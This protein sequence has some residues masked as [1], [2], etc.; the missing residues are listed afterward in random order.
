[1]KTQ[2]LH[3]E[4]YDDRHSISDKLDWGHA[5][6]A[7]LIWP[8]RGQPLANKLDLNLIHRRCQTAGMKLALVCRDSSVKEYAQGLDIPVFRSLRKA[9]QVVWEYSLPANKDLSGIKPE[10]KF[11]REELK[12]Q[13]KSTQEPS[14][15]DQPAVRT[16]AVVT[17]VLALLVMVLFLVPS[18]KITYLPELETQ[19][20]QLVVL[21][22]PKINAFNLSGTLPVENVTV[23]VEGRDELV[24]SGQLGI[25][26][27]SASG[28]IEFTNLTNQ[29]ILIPA[30]TIIRPADPASNIRFI[31]STE[32]TLPS[33]VGAT[34]SGPI[35]AVNPGSNSNLPENSLSV[36]DGPLSLSLTATNPQPTS[37]GNERLSAAPTL[38]DYD[39]LHDQL[40][41]SLQAHALEELQTTLEEGDIILF[42]QAVKITISEESFTPEEPQPSNTL[43]LLLRVDFDVY[44]IRWETFQ[45]MGNAILDATL[46]EG[47][48][49]QPDTL[50]VTPVGEPVLGA[51]ETSTWEVVIFRQVF[52]SRDIPS[53]LHEITGKSSQQASLILQDQLNLAS[54]PEIEIS[55]SWWPWLPLLG[56][57]IS[58]NDFW[59]A[60]Q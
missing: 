4:A 49:S 21:A 28:L 47:Y 5:E 59:V 43:S 10:R 20:L 8:L 22:D 26:Y 54:E 51:D 52:A 29:S 11:T 46:S 3:L 18:A 53:A 56:S 14:W 35:E 9:Q 45:A 55:P 30:G 38:K 37:G 27:Q 39:A 57:R 7:I 25:P 48:T 1:M 32:M 34:V 23:S 19:S 31:T 16:S 6:R 13:L 17:S 12:Q 33:E 42:N 41:H 60:P 2:I 58:I 24:P 50:S 36:I 15:M 40:I 44:V